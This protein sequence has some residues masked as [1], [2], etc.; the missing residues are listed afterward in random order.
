M[1][2]SAATVARRDLAAA[3]SAAS[4]PRSRSVATTRWPCLVLDAGEDG[5]RGV[6][7]HR[8][9]V[10]FDAARSHARVRSTDIVGRFG[11]DDD[12]GDNISE[13]ADIVAAIE[14]RDETSGKT[15]AY[16]DDRSPTPGDT[17]GVTEQLFSTLRR[18][19]K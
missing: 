10:F 12:D 14:V 4:R 17:F 18:K 9:V 3:R 6:T 1:P 5:V 19:P 15:I 13:R 8:H 16:L 7:T 11:G 2:F